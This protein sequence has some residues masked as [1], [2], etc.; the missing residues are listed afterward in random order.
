MSPVIAVQYNLVKD[1][2]GKTFFDDWNFYNNYDNLTNGDA[3]CVAI[4]SCTDSRF[5]HYSLSFVGR[6]NQN[7][8]YVDSSTGRAIMKVDNTTNVVYNDKRNTHLITWG[9]VFVA[10][11]YH[12]PYGCSVWPAW[13]SQ[14]SNWPTGGEIDTFEGVNM[15]TSNQMAL[16]TTQGC[17]QVNPVQSSTLVNSTDCNYQSNSNEGCVPLLR[18]GGGVFVTEFAESG[19]SSFGTPVANWPNGGCSIDKFFASQYLIFDIS[20]CGGDNPT[21]LPGRP[22]VFAETCSGN[23]YTDYVVGS[24]SNYS[25][26]YFDV[27]SVRVYGSGSSNKNTAST[28]RSLW[29]IL[30]TVLGAGSAIAWLI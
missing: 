17:T 22:N 28:Q 11:F 15:V 12:V 18:P 23:C 13:W 14:A 4:S 6:D 27:A 21:T 1:Y 26:A 16:H 24:G 9:S 19:I 5:N 20:L 30:P 2:S 29:S 10:D 8:A 7:L 3:M 25:T